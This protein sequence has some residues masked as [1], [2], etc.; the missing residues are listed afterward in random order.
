MFPR[1]IIALFF[2]M[3]F[4]A[5]AFAQVKQP[6]D[7]IPE[8]SLEELLRL[9]ALD[10]SSVTEAELNARIEAASQRPFSTRET[11]NV[12]TVIT[13][14]EIRN[15]GARDLIDVLRLVPGIEF[16]T[17]VE[18]VISIGI[19]GQWAAEGKMLVAV[20]GVEMN[21]IM[22]GFYTFGN[23][24]PVT[25]IKRVEVVRGPGSV[26]N[27]GFAALGVI[28]IITRDVTDQHGVLVSGAAGAT[29]SGFSRSSA[30]FSW[31]TH[32]NDGWHLGIRGGLSASILSDQRFTDIYGNS[33][34]MRLGSEIQRQ[35][36][37]ATI[38]GH[39][40]NI[41]LMY[42][43]HEMATRTPYDSI[44][45]NLNYTS[46]FNQYRASINYARKFS[47]GWTFSTG[48]NLNYD[49]PWRTTTQIRNVE[50]YDRTG[51]RTKFTSNIGYS[52]TRNLSVNFGLQSFIDQGKTNIDTLKFNTTDSV[53]FTVRNQSAYTEIIWK[54]YWFNII[55]GLR[56]EFNS[57]Y[58]SALV[59]RLAVTK[60]FER[61]SFKLLANQSFKAPTLENIDL[62]DQLNPVGPEYVFVG[63]LEVGYKINRNAYVNANVFRTDLQNPILYVFDDAT[64]SEYYVNEE[65]QISYGAEAEFIWRDAVNQFRASW[66]YYTI[67]SDFVSDQNAV[68]GNDKLLLNF[69]QHK[70]VLMATRKLTSD[71][72]VNF[73]SLLMSERYLYSSVD[74][75]GNLV[76]QRYKPDVMLSGTIN[77]RNVVPGFDVSFSIHNMLNRRFVFGQPY[78]GGLA[79]TNSL[80][81][82]F[83]IRIT[84][85]PTLNK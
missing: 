29:Q 16:G 18:G 39:G 1:R 52:F 63:E 82:E 8:L 60:N 32:S 42:R 21:E 48:I 64:G 57:A 4:C 43:Q 24:F 36:A 40:L 80:S 83:L 12:V 44:Y 84:W 78:N 15:S 56:G 30:E 75:Q 79:P 26:V 35:D 3:Q 23:D 20:D 51:K 17:D 76:V 11:P 22:F 65:R 14:D 68:P 5:I 61:F 33:Y 67:N 31:N 72:V 6:T 81:R 28:N 59:P 47:S 10:S 38:S 2:V 19:R 7:T 13:A 70:I 25:A 55:A 9:K 34:N 53:Y 49:R 54:T 66:S 37:A 77:K 45:N 71:W 50:L 27:G 41:I 74:T 85:H 58:G 69:P 73:S 46:H 62:Q